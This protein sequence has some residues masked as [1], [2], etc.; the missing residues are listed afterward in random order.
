[1]TKP[2]KTENQNDTENTTTKIE[3]TE[4][5]S[6]KSD[7]DL[8]CKTELTFN[9]DAKESKKTLTFSEN[10]VEIIDDKDNVDLDVSMPIDLSQDKDTS[11]EQEA[12]I[13]S[14]KSTDSSSQQSAYEVDMDMPTKEEED[15]YEIPCSQI[16]RCPAISS[17]LV[18]WMMVMIVTQR[19]WLTQIT[20]TQMK[21]NA[22]KLWLVLLLSGSSLLVKDGD[23]QNYKAH[24]TSLLHVASS[25]SR[26][27]VS[28]QVAFEKINLPHMLY[29]TIILLVKNLLSNQYC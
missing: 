14:Y 18:K 2:K 21:G 9:R 10:K 5:K 19:I 1:M 23:K 26:D 22:L 28:L 29:F 13:E 16:K 8:K 17:D 12:S 20:K 15:D 6:G 11:T 7:E 27:E 3:N 25:E 4:T 24:K